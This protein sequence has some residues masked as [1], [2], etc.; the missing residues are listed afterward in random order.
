MFLYVFGIGYLVTCFVIFCLA[1]Y[2]KFT[3]KLD[4]ETK[5][6]CADCGTSDDVNLHT[7]PF[8][9]AVHNEEVNVYLCGHCYAERALEVKDELSQ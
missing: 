9:L 5:P 6:R 2:V 1:V 7:C 8:A 3:E 4:D